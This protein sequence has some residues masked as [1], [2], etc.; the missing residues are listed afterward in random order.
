MENQTKPVRLG[1]LPWREI[2]G[3]VVL[4]QTGRGEVHELN[5]TASFLWSRADG[6]CSVAE[7]A[8]KLAEE[9]EMTGESAQA[10]ALEFFTDLENRGLLSEA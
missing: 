7:L 4:V 3:R 6:A 5:A 8:A 1:K 9:F 2:D 10:D